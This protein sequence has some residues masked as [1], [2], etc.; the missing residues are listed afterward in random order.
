MQ[1]L[2]FRGCFV[3]LTVACDPRP[4]V[5]SVQCP[6]PYYSSV[7][8]L[9][10]G[11]LDSGILLHRLLCSST[12]V[13]P[14]YLQCGLRWERVELYWLHQLLR[15]IPSARLAPLQ[16][17]TLP[18]GSLYGATHWSMTGHTIPSAR[19]PDAAVYLPGRNL[20]LITAAAIHCTT[21]RVSTIALGVLKGNPFGDANPRCLAHLSACLSQALDHPFHI[22]TPLRRFT[23]AQ[24]IHAA[25]GVPLA[26]TFS[27][28]SP[29]GRNH[30]GRCN[31]CAERHR[32]FRHAG[33]AD[34]TRYVRSEYVNA[35]LKRG[36]FSFSST[37]WPGRKIETSPGR[38]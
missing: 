31:K 26:L 29:R 18:F 13:V 27:C 36:R 17:I 15:T 35:N 12:R 6:M 7:C 19:S 4:R 23:K 24:L 28:L 25:K 37:R 1:R 9:V 33:V 34:P 32:A 30:C 20:V 11:G 10:S 8:A 21:Q 3:S 38:L 16:T 14:I 5:P 2:T 22:T